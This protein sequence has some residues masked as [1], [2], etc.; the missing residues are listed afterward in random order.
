MVVL[1]GE[2]REGIR[3]EKYFHGGGG[4]DETCWKYGNRTF[5]ELASSKSRERKSI[6][7][8]RERNDIETDG[9]LVLSM[10]TTRKL[11]IPR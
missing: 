9:L 11:R 6:D 5:N 7:R 1:K 3:V 10:S 4:G 8:G 2:Q